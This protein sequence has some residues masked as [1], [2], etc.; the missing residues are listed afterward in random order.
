VVDGRVMDEETGEVMQGKA[1]E[2]FEAHSKIVGGQSAVRAGLNAMARVPRAARVAGVAGARLRDA[3]L[4]Y[5]AQPDVELSKSEFERAAD[6]WQTYVLD[7]GA[8]PGLLAGASP[9]KLE[10]PLPALKQ[11]VVDAEQA[12]ADAESMT[13]R[14]C[15]SITGGCWGRRT[16]RSRSASGAD[17][18]DW[19]GAKAHEDSFAGDD[20]ESRRRDVDEGAG[21]VGVRTER[22]TSGSSETS[23]IRSSRGPATPRPKLIEEAQKPRVGPCLR[24]DDW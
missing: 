3:E 6:I 8:E 12:A 10:V 11:G 5:L 4:E 21:V 2:A 1:A 18:R 14:I 20:D 24:G 23:S 7:G 15:V 9:S 19:D 13:R 17:Y 22:V 16:T